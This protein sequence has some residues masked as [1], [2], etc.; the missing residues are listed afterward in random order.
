MTYSKIL[1]GA[2][3]TDKYDALCSL[4]IPALRIRVFT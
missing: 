2:G 4:F 1:V 3:K